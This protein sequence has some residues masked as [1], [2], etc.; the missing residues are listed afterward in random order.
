MR[1][2]VYYQGGGGRGNTNRGEGSTCGSESGGSGRDKEVK[3]EGCFRCG[4]VDHKSKEC[5]KKDS[6]CTWCG[7]T[8]HIERT[9]YSKANGS[10]GGGKTGRRGTRG[11][12]RGGRG[13]YCR[14]GEVEE[15][16]PEHGLA[17]V[18]MREVNMRTGDGD[19]EEKEW[20]CDSG[21]DFHMSGDRSL[22]DFLVPI[23]A[24]FFVKQI[25]WPSQSGE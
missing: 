4:E 16:G 23:R 8:C 25:M 6:V 13:G 9:C 21:A 22:F 11:R 15:E 7:A 1:G 14:L 3:S 24:T 12:G 19:G 2:E 10:A 18:L 20:V 5:P 17:E